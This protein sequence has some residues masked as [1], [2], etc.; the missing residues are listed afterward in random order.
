[1]FAIPKLWFDN[2]FWESDHP[3]HVMIT[4][5]ASH[6]VYT[7]L[8]IP[9]YSLT[10]NRTIRRNNG[11]NIRLPHDYRMDVGDGKQNKTI[12]VRASD[13]VSV[14]AITNEYHGSD[15][16]Q[17]IPSL[18]LGTTYYVVSYQPFNGTLYPSF[19]CISAL[20]SDTS[21]SISKQSV[22]IHTVTLRP[23][24]SYRYDGD[25]DLS[26]T[27]IQSDKPIAV[28]SGSA[29]T[30]LPEDLGG[31]KDGLVSEL[32]PT[33]SW[34][35]LYHIFPFESLTGGYIYRVYASNISTTL[36]MSNGNVT[37]IQPG[38][39]YEGDA[40]GDEVISFKADQNV[41][42]SQYM[43]S[44]RFN[45][46]W[47]GDPS[48]LVVPPVSSYTHDVTFPVFEYT[49]VNDSVYIKRNHKFSYYISVVI[50]CENIDGLH[51][52]NQTSTTS[53]TKLT[54]DDQ[55]MCCLRREVSP[56]YYSVTHSHPMVR[57]FV[58]VYCTCTCTASYAFV[59]RGSN[60][61]GKY[62]TL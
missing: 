22:L 8:S 45:E 34:G 37:V 40:S 18:Q 39:F 17:S 6:P 15:V 42:V 59:A 33:K 32:L 57:F 51:L 53:W 30:D 24:E 41:T 54:T 2:K 14:Y 56:G 9:G 20:Q 58:S 48:M 11:A 60:V 27:L 35:L 16:F 43:K 5:L 4:T 12:I 26:G 23:Y 31:S 50:E 44:R 10:I 55:T 21:V 46:P 52:N 38:D 61:Q 7:T 49:F 1:M 29:V 13:T 62:K 19:V 36:Q 25:V 28:I 3:P 47:R